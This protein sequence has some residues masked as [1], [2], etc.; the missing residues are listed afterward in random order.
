VDYEDVDLGGSAPAGYS[1][2]EQAE[3]EKHLTDLGYL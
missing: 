3:V 1:D 2:A